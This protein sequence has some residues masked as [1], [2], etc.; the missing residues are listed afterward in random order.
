MVSWLLGK[1]VCNMPEAEQGIY[2]SSG[3]LLHTKPC[4]WP[5]KA[6]SNEMGLLT[7]VKESSQV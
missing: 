1:A 3:N 4:K 5:T 7:G 2:Q 6:C